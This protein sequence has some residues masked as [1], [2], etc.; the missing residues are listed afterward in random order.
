[1]VWYAAI[2]VAEQNIGRA[3]A[4]AE[5]AKLPNILNFTVRRTAA[6]NTPEAFAAITQTL[7]RATDDT[8]RL[9]IL[10]GLSFALKG[11]RNAPMPSGWAAIETSLSSSTN[12]EV[13]SLAQSLSLT[14]GS[15]NAVASLK[16]TLMDGSADPNAR[17]MAAESLLG[18]RESGMAPL[19]QELVKD[20]E[21]QPLA[22]RGLAAY[23]DN[24]TPSSILRGVWL[25][26]REPQARCA[27]HPGL[28]RSLRQTS[29][30]RH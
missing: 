25:A 7:E 9:A 11:R 6:L 2:P 30:L 10:N 4:M 21:L 22:L 14:F 5:T 1:M 16:K 3:L 29:A 15:A 23:D 17:R 26:R 13:R 18:A 28:P 24:N 20:P 27:Q 8:H 19:L 12:T